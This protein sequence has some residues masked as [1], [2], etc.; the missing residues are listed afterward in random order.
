MSFIEY[1]M[2][3][4]NIIYADPPWHFENGFWDRSASNPSSHYNTMSILDICNLPIASITAINCHLYMWTTSRHLMNGDAIKVVTSWGFE[5]MNIITWCKPQISLGYYFR[6]STEH[7]IF[8]KKGKFH[9]LD[10][11]QNTHFIYSRLKHSEKPPIVKDI[12]VKCSG[13]LPR[14]ELF[15]RQKTEGWD[16]W[17]NEV[18]SDIE[19]SS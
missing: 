1:I 10:R 9:T 19:L 2:K 3:K 16:V 4:Y 13:N 12:I 14:I 17:G 11:T 7:L 5:P 15:A 6:N 18:D 8:A